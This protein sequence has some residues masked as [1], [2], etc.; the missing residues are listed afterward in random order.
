MHFTHLNC[1]VQCFFSTF[2]DVCSHH[3]TV[4]ECFAPL[5]R[6]FVPFAIISVVS[7][8]PP[9]ALNNLPYPMDYLSLHKAFWH[10]LLRA[11]VVHLFNDFSRLILQ[12]FYSLSC[13][14]L[15]VSVLFFQQSG[16]NRKI[17]PSTPR[18]KKEK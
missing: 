12:R 5:K 10:C 1:T 2:S 9:P 8:F 16:S 13:I 4:L 14:L 18:D 3:Q 6:N 7:A 11:A 15:E 17:L